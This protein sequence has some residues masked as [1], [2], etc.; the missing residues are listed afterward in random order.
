MLWEHDEEST[1]NSDTTFVLSHETFP[2][3]EAV[4]NKQDSK[5]LMFVINIG[6][7]SKDTKIFVLDNEGKFMFDTKH[8]E[9]WLSMLGLNRLDNEENST[10]SSPTYE[11]FDENG[12]RA[13]LELKINKYGHKLNQLILKY[14]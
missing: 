4:Y 14:V 9:Y 5:L 10:L 1:L 7:L 6:K 8:I 12:D 3:V 13:E 11:L 2:G